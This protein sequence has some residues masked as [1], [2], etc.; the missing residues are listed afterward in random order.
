MKKILLFS[1][2]IVF[3]Q[4]KTDAQAIITKAEYNKTMQSAVSKE[5][6]FEKGTTEDAIVSKMK[7]LG[8]SAKSSKGFTV[9][10]MVKI[11]ELGSETFD[12]YFSTDKKSKKE[13]DKSIVTLL[14]SKGYDNFVNDTT[15]SEI[16]AN[17]QN[18]LNNILAPIVAYDLE[19]QISAQEELVKKADKKYNNTVDDGGSLEKKRKSIES[20]IEENKKDQANKKNEAEA[21]RQVLET[22]RSKRVK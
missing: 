8:Y 17:G 11:Q 13:K 9:F 20:D 16:L 7:S 12:L 1:L 22:L 10:K 6:P 5:F 21:Q 2:L 15:G 19:K 4:I 18:L 14:I 3:C